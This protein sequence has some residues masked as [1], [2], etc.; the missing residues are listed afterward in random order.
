MARSA[1]E[2]EL[3][4]EIQNRQGIVAVRRRRYQEG[5]S[6][7]RQALEYAAKHSLKSLEISATGSLGNRFMRERRYEEAIPYF[8]DSSA[9]AHKAGAVET[10]ARNIGNAGFCY[11]EVGDLDRAIKNMRQAESAF[12]ETGNRAEQ[13]TW[14]GLIGNVYLA[15]SEYPEAAG[16]YKHAIEISHVLGE[17]GAADE[18]SWLSNL[19]RVLIQTGDFDAAERYNSEALV[20]K[21]RRKDTD[22][23]ASSLVNAAAI[24]FGR[25]EYPEAEAIV[26]EI[27]RSPG[28]DP[29]PRLRAHEQLA[30]ILDATHRNAAAEAEFRSTIR[31][32]E[33]RRNE[34]RRDDSK[35][36][37]LSFLIGFYQH[38]TGFL[39]EHGKSNEA[40]AVADSSYARTMMERPG[41]A[42]ATQRRTDF[43]KLAAATGST[44]LVYSLGE[45]SFLWVITPDAIKP[46]QLP[47]ESAIRPL[48]MAHRKAIQDLRDPIQ[49]PNPI[50]Q[51][52]YQTLVAPAAAEVARTGRAIIVPDGLLYLL[53]FETLVV[54]GA[55]PHYF[56][57]DATISIVP[58]L[59]LLKVAPKGT[60]VPGSLLLIGNPVSP[61]PAFPDLEYA[62]Q[63]MAF[64]EQSL[65]SARKL[66]LKR[67]DARPDTWEESKPADY[68]LIHFT[69]HAAAS[70]EDPLESAIILSKGAGGAYR[71]HA[72]DVMK[73]RLKARLVTISACSGAGIRI[74]SG[75]G[76]VGLAWAFLESGAHNVI[77]GLWDVSDQSS[78]KTMARLYTGLAAG[79]SPATALRDAKL[80]L[81]HAGIYRKPWY[82]APFQLFTT[83]IAVETNPVNAAENAH[84]AR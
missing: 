7:I 41:T 4:A 12:Q 71:L 62:A 78:A 30:V 80:E 52:L 14:L 1:G 17:Q 58:S 65:P 84:P 43:K 76:L 20:I 44:L 60:N 66:I 68:D 40:L 29:T 36:S 21:R 56:I 75:E 24:A 18:A 59:G 69:A 45:K 26:R 22:A 35:L 79:S 46:V 38:F 34:L 42:Q 57:E 74:Y 72:R 39:M 3:L 63:E 53:N 47:A 19:S 31:E 49:E 54:P 77:A 81:I 51:E 11:Y 83:E 28:E 25:H 16:Y 64:I 8:E 82:W 48:I 37:Y 67:N 70:R 5:E 2:E 13:K 10:E 27:L 32:I 6:L 73:T 61:D 15:R 55:T 9:A 23:E 50:A 33:S